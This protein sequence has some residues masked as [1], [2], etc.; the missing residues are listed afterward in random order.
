VR[1]A[2]TRPACPRPARWDLHA[3][4]LHGPIERE[5]RR[6]AAARDAEL[7]KDSLMESY[8]WAIHRYQ[9]DHEPPSAGG[10]S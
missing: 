6:A 2:R 7:G 3:R 9:R 5:A 4:D 10:G 8:L 1:H